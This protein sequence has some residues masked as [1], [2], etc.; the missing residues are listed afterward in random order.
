MKYRIKQIIKNK[1][2]TYT[3]IS[4]K[5]NLNRQTISNW[6]NGETIINLDKLESLS[7]A[8]NCEVHE[9]LEC[10]DNYTHAY[11]PVGEWLG[12]IKK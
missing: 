6:I 3:D 11:S 7:M 2:L 1:N 4:V 8:L 5:L 12:I 10:G 9:L